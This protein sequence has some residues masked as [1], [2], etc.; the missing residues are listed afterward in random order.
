MDE[1]NTSE[2]ALSRIRGIYKYISYTRD[3]RPETPRTAEIIYSAMRLL[4]VWIARYNSIG[5]NSISLAKV[6]NGVF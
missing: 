5:P 6:F 2:F 3:S 1:Y 4:H